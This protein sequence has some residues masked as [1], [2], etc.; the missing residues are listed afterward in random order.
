LKNVNLIRG[1][2]KLCPEEKDV[3]ESWRDV[4]KAF[5]QVKQ[6]FEKDD[7]SVVIPIESWIKTADNVGILIIQAT[8][9]L[10][11]IVNTQDKAYRTLRDI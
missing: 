6:D 10:T 2:R 11:E 4:K 3:F 8:E 7:D 1:M 9:L 5:Q